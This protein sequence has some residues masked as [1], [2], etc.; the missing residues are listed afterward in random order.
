MSMR[1]PLL[2]AACIAVLA[3]GVFAL[4]LAA[5]VGAAIGV[6]Y[7]LVVLLSLQLPRR[8]YCIFVAG[9]CSLLIIA[10]GFTK[11]ALIPGLTPPLLIANCVLELITVWI[12]AMFA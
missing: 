2:L 1:H 3:A 7:I 4:D 8:Q 9:Y 6:L 10:A 11:A 12:T 5:P